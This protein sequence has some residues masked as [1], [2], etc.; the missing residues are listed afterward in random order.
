MPE[1]ARGGVDGGR[2]A[3][4][5][6]GPA[7]PGSAA[8]RGGVFS[9]AAARSIRCSAGGMS[10]AAPGWRRFQAGITDRQA[11]K[12][13]GVPKAVRRCI[14][15]QPLPRKAV[16]KP[17][18]PRWYRAATAT[19]QPCRA[20]AGPMP[21]HVVRRCITCRGFAALREGACRCA[22]PLPHSVSMRYRIVHGVRLA[23]AL[24]CPATQPT[25]LCLARCTFAA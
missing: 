16:A 12:G 5:A 20:T 8:G 4:G 25:D 22:F 14:P 3:P 1:G 21:G 10:Q 23:A 13:V 18:V 17:A 15:G 7:S 11:R 9:S 19:N 24:G 6:A 2:R